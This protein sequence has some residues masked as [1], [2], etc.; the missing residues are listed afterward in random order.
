MCVGIMGSGTSRESELAVVWDGL[1]KSISTFVI[2]MDHYDC[3]MIQAPLKHCDKMIQWLLGFCGVHPGTLFGILTFCNIIKSLVSR[4]ESQGGFLNAAD[5][6]EHLLGVMGKPR[7]WVEAWT[8]AAHPWTCVDLCRAT[9][10][11]CFQTSDNVVIATEG[12][13]QT[14]L[15][16][17]R[18]R[19]LSVRPMMS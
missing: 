15:E 8:A 5:L 12:R 9:S 1:Q 14:C 11:F 19:N 10:V 4:C 2:S 18:T 16:T 6:R 7:P 3:D 17:G 13:A